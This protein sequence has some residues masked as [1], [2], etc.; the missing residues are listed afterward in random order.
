MG[1][2]GI[3]KLRSGVWAW[4]SK[5]VREGGGG[6]VDRTTFFLQLHD[7]ERSRMRFAVPGA[8]PEVDESLSREAR[9]VARRFVEHHLERRLLS[10]AV[11][12]G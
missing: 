2:R 4:D 3:V 10:P 6:K 11:L 1:A 12:D 5:E 9:G 7:S 8:L